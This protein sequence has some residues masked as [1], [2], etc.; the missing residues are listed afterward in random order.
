[1]FMNDD[2]QHRWVL[3]QELTARTLDMA[4]ISEERLVS[5]NISLQLWI[6]PSWQQGL[7]RPVQYRRSQE[8]QGRFEK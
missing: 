5:Q 6:A 3:G 2:L 4:A 1:M 7:F 8:L